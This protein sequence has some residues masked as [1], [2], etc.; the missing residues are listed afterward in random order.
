M[1]LLR[2]WFSVTR[3]RFMCVVR[4]TWSETSVAPSQLTQFWQISYPLSSPYF[5]TTAPSGEICKYAMVPITHKL[6]RFGTYWCAPFCCTYLDY[7]AAKFETSGGT[8]ELRCITS[9][10]RKPSL[11]ALGLDSEGSVKII[12]D[13]VET[14]GSITDDKR[15]GRNSAG[16]VFI[17]FFFGFSFLIITSTLLPSHLSP[18]L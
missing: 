9:E 7:C 1:G 15:C 6:E 12:V 18:F 10:E 17:R 8:N 2:S 11:Q 5:V 14:Y 3:R 4:W 13:W 16:E